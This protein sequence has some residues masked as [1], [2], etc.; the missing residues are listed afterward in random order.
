MAR[1]FRMA[2]LF[3]LALVAC[4]KTAKPT[5]DGA[6][7]SAS[8]GGN[9]FVRGPAP[10]TARIVYEKP[11][12]SYRLVFHV[13]DGRV[14][15][16][17][18]GGAWADGSYSIFDADSEVRVRPKDRKRTRFRTA[19]NHLFEEYGKLAPE[20][21]AAVRRSIGLVLPD[22]GYYQEGT[23]ERLDTRNI[24]GLPASCYRRTSTI[25]GIVSE[26]CF[27][28]GIE[29]FKNGKNPIDDSDLRIAVTSAEIGIPIDDALFVIP[30]DYPEE[31]TPS[32]E[33][34][35]HGVYAKLL[36]RMQSP[37]FTIAHLDRYARV[38]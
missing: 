31:S 30:A 7:A 6:P 29:V 14:R 21:Q 32:T 22:L 2:G 9:P 16:E 33:P 10:S 13:K 19:E 36:E 12:G 26:E 38:P 23:L 15:E 8:A 27:W 1:A 37:N 28:R 4:R 34:I 5:G 18:T 24:H 11:D 17:T 3:V 35:M 20:A 25:L